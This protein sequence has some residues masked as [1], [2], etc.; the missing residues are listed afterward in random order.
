MTY[1]TIVFDLTD[2][3][4]TPLTEGGIRDHENASCT[5][6]DGTAPDVIS[7][8]IPLEH[9]AAAAILNL[10]TTGAPD[11]NVLLKAYRSPTGRADDRTLVFHGP[12][13]VD[14]VLGKQRQLAIVAAGP[15]WIL[16]KRP[17][18]AQYVPTDAGTLLKTMIDTTNTSDGETRIATDSSWITASTT[19]DVD[20]R[21]NRPSIQQLRTQFTQMVDGPE[22][23]IQPIELA[24]GKVGRFYAAPRRGADTSVVFAFGDGTEANVED[25]TRARD[26]MKL[27]NDARG[28][29]DAGLSST[30]T[31]EV[32]A[33][34]IGR[35]IEYVSVSGATQ[36]QLDAQ[37]QG[38]IDVASTRDLVAEY[39]IAVSDASP[40]LFDDFV[41]GDGVQLVFRDSGVAWHV[42]KR[43]KSATVLV[44]A[45]GVEVP[46]QVVVAS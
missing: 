29:T 1:P 19:V 46:S 32:S 13:V 23:W 22:T 36:T 17:T 39:A 34:A 28:Y 20:A 4:G 12:V 3:N 35:L 27:V 5:W 38:R 9:D 14:Q 37:M 45:S 25:M 33:A 31:D 21:Q 16:Q 2:T 43:V 30:K 24:A 7:M 18:L 40:R 6:Q 42:T 10:E 26:T 8:S 15:D 44:D 11:R 41:I